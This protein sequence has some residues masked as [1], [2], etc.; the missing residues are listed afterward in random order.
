MTLAVDS[1]GILPANHINNDVQTT[2]SIY[3]NPLRD[4]F[5]RVGPIYSENLIVTYTDLQ[6]VSSVLGYTTDYKCVYPIPTIVAQNE[7]RIYGAIRLLNT[8]LNGS[9]RLDY[10]ALGGGWTYNIPDIIAYQQF[11]S[12]DPTTQEV[13]LAPD[14]NKYDNLDPNI[15][16]SYSKIAAY[17]T[18]FAPVQLGVLYRNIATGG[19][20]TGGGTLPTNIAQ[21]TGGNLEVLAAQSYSQNQALSNILAALQTQLALNSTV[22]FDPTTVPATYYVRRETLN[23]SNGAHAVTWETP[24]GTTATPNVSILQAVSNA[25]NVHNTSSTFTANANGA[26]FSSGDMLVHNVGIDTAGSTPVVAY[27]FWANLGPSVASGTVLATAPS[28]SVLSSIATPITATSLPLPTGAGTAANQASIISILQNTLTTQ[29]TTADLATILLVLQNILAGQ[30]TATGQASIVSALQAVLNTREVQYSSI[31]D[32]TTTPNV[33]Y[34]CEALPG[35][36]PTASVWRISRYDTNTGRT[37]W[38]NGNSNFTNAAF[39]GANPAYPG[40]SYV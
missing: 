10:Q 16:N 39:S 35:S 33:I 9:I 17:Q 11:N 3:T 1:T 40:L 12:F 22:W 13:V 26:G 34:T 30:S 32:A 23:S 37:T 27:S 5:P 7:S 21:E 36:A 2:S 24:T 15:L 4:I 8:D 14:S 38:A 6:G 31:V 28:S 20:S 29:A 18:L 19:G 25:E